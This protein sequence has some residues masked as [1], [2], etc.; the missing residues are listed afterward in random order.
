MFPDQTKE[1]K[2][3][4]QPTDMVLPYCH[5]SHQMGLEDTAPHP[6]LPAFSKSSWCNPLTAGVIEP[7]HPVWAGVRWVWRADDRLLYRESGLLA[8]Q[9]FLGKHNKWLCSFFFFSTSIL[10]RDVGDG[11][12]LSVC[13]FECV[14]PWAPT[15]WHSEIPSPEVKDVSGLVSSCHQPFNKHWVFS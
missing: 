15:C 3:A 9:L 1:K 4:S 14:C 11:S 12:G 6:S 13:V 7:T 5:S 2:S 10:P 8:Q